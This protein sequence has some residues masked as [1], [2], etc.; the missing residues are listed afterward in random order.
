MRLKALKRR[1][2]DGRYI[3]LPLPFGIYSNARKGHIRQSSSKISGYP[4]G[5]RNNYGKCKENGEFM[6]CS[7]CASNKITTSI[8][9]WGDGELVYRCLDCGKEWIEV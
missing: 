7:R 8:S 9:T 4:R 5:I 2:G 3:P 1:F 6:K